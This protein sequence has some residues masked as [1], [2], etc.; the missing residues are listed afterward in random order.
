[1]IMVQYSRFVVEKYLCVGRVNSFFLFLSELIFKQNNTE[2][3]DGSQGEGER[4]SHFFL[5]T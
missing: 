3:C 1:M 2:G 5:H 4:Y